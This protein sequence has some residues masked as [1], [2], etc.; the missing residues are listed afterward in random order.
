MN[1]ANSSLN[2]TLPAAISLDKCGWPTSVHSQ[3]PQPPSIRYLDLCSYPLLLLLTTIGNVLNLLVLRLDKPFGSKGVYLSA[4]A[5]TDLVYMWSAIISYISNYDGEVHGLPRPAIRDM[6]DRLNGFTMFLQE[7]CVIASAWMIVAFTLERFLAIRYPLKHLIFSHGQRSLYVVTGVVSVAAGIAVVRLVDYYWFYTQFI[8]AVPRP[9]R[10]P[11]R[12]KI[13]L[14]WYGTYV[15]AL[16]FIQ[17]GTFIAILLL[18]ALLLRVI[19]RQHRVRRE[20]LHVGEHRSR[21]VDRGAV[22]M[23][24]ACSLCYLLT[25]MPGFA[26]NVLFLLNKACIHQLHPRTVAVLAPILNVLLNVNFSANFLLY[27]GANPRFRKGVKVLMGNQPLDSAT[28]RST[29]DS[30]RKSLES[31]RSMSLVVETLS[32]LLGKCPK[33]ELLR[34]S[35]QG[36]VEKF[37]GEVFRKTGLVVDYRVHCCVDIGSTRRADSI[38]IDCPAGKGFII[39]PTVRFEARLTQPTDVA[40]ERA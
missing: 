32:N 40:S 33:A 29:S 11:P 1:F 16:A 4:V 15:W 2:S 3:R 31:T 20:S 39:D 22:A 36:R 9:P 23:L 26:G 17:I 18:N 24:L 19:A 10:V 35:H 25:Q 34:N 37:L 27:C 5:I 30:R 13:L 6:V 7:T 12:P 38:A 14:E 21:G 8:A 28:D